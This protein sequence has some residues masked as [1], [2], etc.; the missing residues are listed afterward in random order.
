MK[1]KIDEL[2]SKSLRRTETASTTGDTVAS[3]L[4]INHEVSGLIMLS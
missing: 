2:L 4:G 1:K 3:S